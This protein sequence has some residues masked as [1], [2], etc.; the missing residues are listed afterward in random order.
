MGVKEFTGKVARIV[1]HPG[2]PMVSIG[3]DEVRVGFGGG[4]PVFFGGH[5]PISVRL[6]LAVGYQCTKLDVRQEVKPFG[7]GLKI[8]E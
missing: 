7:V 8:P 1:R 3:D 5:F 2:L 4:L 6:S